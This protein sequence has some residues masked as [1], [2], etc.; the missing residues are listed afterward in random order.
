IGYQTAYLKRHYTAEFMAALLSSE[1]DDGNKRDVMVEHIADARH[2][3]V[4]VLPPNVNAGDVGFTVQDG[5]IVFGLTAIKGLGRSAAEEIV[6]ARTEKGP[7]R[8]L[9]DFCERIDHRSVTQA[10]VEKLIKAGAFDKFGKRSALM[11]VLPRY[12][13]ASKEQAE[14]RKRG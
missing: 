9:Y 2:L 8:D 5:K 12:M 10:A 1:I 3:G 6:R 7:F 14:D 13:Q 4:E 11:M